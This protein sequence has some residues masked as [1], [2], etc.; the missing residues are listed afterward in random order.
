MTGKRA[1]LYYGIISGFFLGFF[2]FA[3]GVY[4]HSY[5]RNYQETHIINS[6]SST[7][8]ITP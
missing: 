4:T 8:G 6:P 2:Y 5:R 3:F 1:W 7:A